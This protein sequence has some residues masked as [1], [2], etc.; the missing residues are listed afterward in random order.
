MSGES[1]PFSRARHNAETA[2]II[3]PTL[4]VALLFPSSAEK[5]FAVTGAP[6]VR[7]VHALPGC[8][9]AISAVS[10]MAW[11]GICCCV[12]ACCNKGMHIGLAAYL[13]TWMMCLL[14]SQ[15]GAT[16]WLSRPTPTC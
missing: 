6:P 8:I 9:A 3:L 7:H 16:T 12:E 13:A 10:A 11:I 4:A 1:A 15:T 5:I 2:A 14:K